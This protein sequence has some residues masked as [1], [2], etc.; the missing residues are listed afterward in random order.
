MKGPVFPDF[1]PVPPVAG[2]KSC[3]VRRSQRGCLNAFRAKNIT[4]ENI[5]LKLHK[6]VVGAC[7]AIHLQFIQADSGVGLHSLQHLPGLVIEGLQCRP[8]KMVPADTA[9]QTDNNTA[10]IL[11][12]VG[13]SQTG[14]GRYHV[15]AVGIRHRQAQLLRLGCCFNKAQ[16]ISQPLNSRTGD[17]NT[18][19]QRVADRFSVQTGGDGCQKPVLRDYRFV[20]GIHQKEA[21]GA[22]GVLRIT[23][24]KTALAE[25]RR[26]LIAGSSGNR[27][28]VADRAVFCISEN[29]AR[30]FHL[31]QHLSGNG[32]SVQYFITPFQLVDIKHHGPGR[33]RVVCRMNLTSGQVPDQPGIHRTEK[34]LSFFRLLT[35]S[36]HIIQNPFQ[37]GSGEIG[38]RNEPGVLPDIFTEALRF[39]YIDDR[40]RSPALPYDGVIYRLSG[41][42]IPH[43]GRLTLICDTDSRN[44][45]GGRADAAHRLRG[46][47]NLA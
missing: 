10:G 31:R 12:P 18:S 45:R 36:R 37:L 38:I 23:G 39:Q 16:F 43:N 13:G 20:S 22:I 25:E 30:G 28:T 1:F 42:F 27:N 32:Q 15:D 33:I 35:G 14:K 2:G 47:R 40:R 3:Q 29:A 41:I 8:D 7:T 4:I 24:V 19:F 46:D 44:V 9:G 11:I 17:E 26:L 5:R 6:E 21:A 34:K